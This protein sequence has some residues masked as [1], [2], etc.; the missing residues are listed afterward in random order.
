MVKLDDNRFAIMYTTSKAYNK[1]LKLHYVVVD[2]KGKKVYSKTYS[3]ML[4]GGGTQPIVYNGRVVWADFDF[5]TGKNK[6]YGVPA[7][8]K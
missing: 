6:I 4:F 5:A 1:N 2:G 8:V 3:N 7:L